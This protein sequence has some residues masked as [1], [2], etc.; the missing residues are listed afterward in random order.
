[1]GL[2]AGKGAGPE[3]VRQEPDR[4]VFRD[5]INEISMRLKADR[6]LWA[7][8]DIHS[9]ATAIVTGVWADAIQ[10]KERGEAPNFIPLTQV[11][12]S[13]EVAERMLRHLLATF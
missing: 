9:R 4:T 10:A 13:D 8:S 7:E 1:M 3:P 11:G 6:K 2:D 12:A 5:A